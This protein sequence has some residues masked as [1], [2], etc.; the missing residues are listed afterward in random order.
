MPA[1]PLHPAELL[2]AFPDAR[3]VW[4]WR[5]PLAVVASL[6]ETFRGG[7][8]ELWLFKPDLRDAIDRMVRAYDPSD[9]RIA[10]VRYEDLVQGDDEPWRALFARLDLPWDASVL[11]RFRETELRGRYGDRWGHAR[12]AGL[13]ADRVDGWLPPSRGGRDAAGHAVTSTGSAPTGS[14]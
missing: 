8:F 3:F 7:R 9:P 14:P 11:D 6:L 1:L 2:D 12:Y 5:N 13:A 10:A 4:L